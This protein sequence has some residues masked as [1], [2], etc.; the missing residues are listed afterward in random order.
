VFQA[1]E[2]LPAREALPDFWLF[3]AQALQGRPRNGRRAGGVINSVSA[4]VINP[5]LKFLFD[6][7]QELEDLAQLATEAPWDEA[8][9]DDRT[10]I[11]MAA[12]LAPLYKLA[13]EYGETCGKARG[14]REACLELTEAKAP[15]LVSVLEGHL[16]DTTDVAKI[17]KLLRDLGL[18]LDE[19]AVQSAI[20]H[21]LG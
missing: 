21:Y 15:G 8:L 7:E 19:E 16:R 12:L 17:K 18:A 9:W 5:V 4:P 20:A 3:D 11:E 13:R 2:G 14:L 10:R 6:Q 1:G